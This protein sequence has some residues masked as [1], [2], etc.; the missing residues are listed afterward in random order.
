MRVR[1]V[2]FFLLGSS[3]LPKKRVKKIKNREALTARQ[4]KPRHAKVFFTCETVGGPDSAG[5]I[6]GQPKDGCTTAHRI[7]GQPTEKQ[8][9]DS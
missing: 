8:R 9:L 6:A 7:A 2:T 5:C 3:F 1:Y 4:L